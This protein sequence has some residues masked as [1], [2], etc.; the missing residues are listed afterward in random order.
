MDSMMEV[1]GSWAAFFIEINFPVLL[2]RQRIDF[3]FMVSPTD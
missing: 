1:L 3:F 2:S